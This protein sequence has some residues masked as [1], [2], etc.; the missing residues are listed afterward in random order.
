MIYLQLPSCLQSVDPLICYLD[1]S[2]DILY[3]KLEAIIF[4]P[5]LEQIWYA[6]LDAFQDTLLHGV[7]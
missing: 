2:L 7:S 5:L 3:E 4:P 1:T 6:L